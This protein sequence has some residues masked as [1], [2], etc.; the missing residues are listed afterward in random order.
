MTKARFERDLSRT[1]PSWSEGS[2]TIPKIA[3]TIRQ[4][5]QSA[6]SIDT[7]RYVKS[8]CVAKNLVDHCP[9]LQEAAARSSFLLSLR[10][11]SGRVHGAMPFAAQWRVELLAMQKMQSNA[12]IQSMKTT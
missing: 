10:A 4:T 3:H 7:V 5:M 2:P 11:C 8:F 9:F 1:K 6:Q 12:S